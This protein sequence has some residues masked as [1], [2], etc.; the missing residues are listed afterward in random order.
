MTSRAPTAAR[1]RLYVSDRSAPGVQADTEAEMDAAWVD[2]TANN[3]ASPLKTGVQ[4][5]RSD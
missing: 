5:I 3:N 2:A 1:D 4:L